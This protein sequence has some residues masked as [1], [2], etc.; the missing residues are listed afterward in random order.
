MGA[1]NRRPLWQRD[2]CCRTW[3]GR[4]AAIRETRQFSR[5]D[6][7]AS[8]A[9]DCQHY[10]RWRRTVLRLHPF[11]RQEARPI[12]GDSE[13][14]D[15]CRPQD[16]RDLRFRRLPDRTGSEPDLRRGALRNM[17]HPQT[18]RA[19]ILENSGG[20]PEASVKELTAD[21]LPDGDVLVSVAYSSLNYKDALAVTNPGKSEEH[22]SEL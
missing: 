5:T 16:R 21:S 18:F 1:K 17:P 12:R 7:G 19:L 9:E 22:T 6:A 20:K 14:R 11:L 15:L 2:C 10:R 13:S 8:R 4:R 3:C